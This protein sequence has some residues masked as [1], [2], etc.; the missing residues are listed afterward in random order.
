MKKI[1]L[2]VFLILA[3]SSFSKAQGYDIK[4]KI[5]GMRDSSIY[6][7]YYFAE[8]TYVKDTIKLDANGSGTFKGKEK[9]DGGM[10]F[11]VL[12]NKTI[13]WEML[14]SDSQNF[15]VSACVNSTFSLM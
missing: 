2:F 12:P 11:I 13:A 6:L 4:V 1:Q 8:K 7:G 3:I 5:N 9:L 15:S 14:I 10:Y